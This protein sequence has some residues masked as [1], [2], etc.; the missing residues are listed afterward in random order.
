MFI[1]YSGFCK[2]IVFADRLKLFDLLNM[3]DILDSVLICIKLSVCTCI[4]L[5]LVIV[6][7]QA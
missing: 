5:N 3:P 6:T 1:F 4:N 2:D 7:P